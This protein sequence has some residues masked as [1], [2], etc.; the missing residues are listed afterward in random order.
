MFVNQTKTFYTAEKE[1]LKQMLLE[2]GKE[3]S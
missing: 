3:R 2:R 1:I